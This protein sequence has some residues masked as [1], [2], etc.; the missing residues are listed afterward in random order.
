[1]TFNKCTIQ[2]KKYGDVGSEENNRGQEGIEEVNL[3]SLINALVY[4][5]ID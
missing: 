2:G 4:V 1:M 3:F 5:Y